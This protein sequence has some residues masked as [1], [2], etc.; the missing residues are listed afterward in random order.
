VA[1]AYP[2]LVG[3]AVERREGRAGEDSF[4]LP[5]L[6]PETRAARARAR[7]RERRLA[8]ALSL[9]ATGTVLALGLRTWV[10]QTYAVTSAAMAGTLV[11]GDEVVVDKLAFELHPVEVG[12]VVVYSAPGAGDGRLEVGRIVALGG[13]VVWSTGD[14]VYVDGAPEPAPADAV[15]PL[16]PPVPR[17]VVPPG[18]VYVLG[19]DRSDAHD[20]RAFGPV[21]LGALVGQV[22][23][24]VWAH[25]HPTLSIL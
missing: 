16:V 13:Q 21:P 10:L 4:A 23:A 25:G 8:V 17:L 7:R 11:P 3:R 15:E 12:D 22:V 1:Q 9:V 24:V 19:D 20:S 6:A 18:D 2:H 5:N 14:T